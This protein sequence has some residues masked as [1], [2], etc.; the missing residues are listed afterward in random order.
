[1]S[2]CRRRMTKTKTLHGLAQNDIR[3]SL[4]NIFCAY[5]EVEYVI[6]IL[7]N[8]PESVDREAAMKRLEGVVLRKLNLSMEQMNSVFK[9]ISVRKE[10]K[11]RTD[12]VK[13]CRKVRGKHFGKFKGRIPR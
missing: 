1:M 4:K 2:C 13:D 10:A 12:L 3:A 9:N 6:G 8:L 7:N 11:R 5:K